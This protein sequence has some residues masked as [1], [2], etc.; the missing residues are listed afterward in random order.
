MASCFDFRMRTSSFDLHQLTRGTKMARFSRLFRSKSESD[1]ILTSPKSSPKPSPGANPHRRRF[2][3]VV[4]NAESEGEE[5]ENPHVVRKFSKDYWEQTQMLP[6]SM[7]LEEG[8]DRPLP[9]TVSGNTILKKHGSLDSSDSPPS[10]ARQPLIFK[11]DVQ[12]IEFDKKEKIKKR[13][14]YMHDEKLQD[15]SDDTDTSSSTS[16]FDIKKHRIKARK[17][18]NVEYSS[19]EESEATLASFAGNVTI[20]EV[21][22]E[23]LV[24]G[25]IPPP[26]FELAASSMCSPVEEEGEDCHDSGSEVSSENSLETGLSL[27]RS[28]RDWS[29]E[30]TDL[31]ATAPSIASKI[32]SAHV[33]MKKDDKTALVA[34]S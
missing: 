30:E 17:M 4:R 14:C 1:A 25:L 27:A 24:L 13:I 7:S 28:K 11:E 29:A 19:E 26:G 20:S 6:K 22:R 9:Y 18:P 2:V 32:M 5:Y 15:S 3:R 31:S 21:G 34:E 23:D 16:E 10:E 12:V 8:V 33:E